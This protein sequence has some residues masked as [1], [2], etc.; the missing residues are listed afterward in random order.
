MHYSTVYGQCTAACIVTSCAL[1]Q[2]I[3][4][5]NDG[6]VLTLRDLEDG[7]NR[8]HSISVRVFVSYCKPLRD[9]T[10]EISRRAGIR[11]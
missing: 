8:R 1:F 4:V 5:S 10:D 7:S 6:H 2:A 3:A 11:C 9:S